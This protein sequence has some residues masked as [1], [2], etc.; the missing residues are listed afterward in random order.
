ML[1]LGFGKSMP[2]NCI[3]IDNLAD[4]VSENFLCKQ[5]SRYGNVSSGVIDRVAGKALIFFT[6]MDDAQFALNEM[7]NRILN[8]KKIVVG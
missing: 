3:W 6:N 5:F 4:T 7:R 1:Q 8:K 2:T